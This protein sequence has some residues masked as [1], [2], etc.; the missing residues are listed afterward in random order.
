MA[1]KTKPKNPKTGSGTRTE[2]PECNS[3]QFWKGP[4]RLI[5]GE[6]ADDWETM[7]IATILQGVFTD[8]RDH[9]PKI[10]KIA[11]QQK[12]IALSF[13]VKT[14]HEVQPP[15]IVVNGTYAEKHNMKFKSDCPDPNAMD[16]PG[17]SRAEV[18]AQQPAK[19]GDEKSEG[20]GEGDTAGK[21]ENEGTG[22]PPY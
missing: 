22:E 2:L 11:K 12:G 6:K 10:N 17:L 16:L 3:P 8:I 4:A 9:Y 7:E 13:S 15:T 19:E 18:E 5:V 20:A 14:D 1:K 21:E